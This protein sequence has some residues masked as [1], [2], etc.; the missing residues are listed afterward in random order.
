[1]D[2]RLLL[3][4]L[5]LGLAGS[6][7][8][9]PIVLDY[10]TEIIG[11][12][13][14]CR[15]DS[16]SWGAVHI[17]NGD[18]MVS[19][20]EHRWFREPS[21]EYNDGWWGRSV[22]FC[23]DKA[24]AI[25]EVRIWN[26]AY[27]YRPNGGAIRNARLFSWDGSDWVEVWSGGLTQTPAGGLDDTFE[28]TDTINLAGVVTERVKFEAVD[29]Y[30]SE[31][32]VL[33]EI[34]FY[35]S[36]ATPRIQ[37]ETTSSDGLES[38]SPAGLTVTLGNAEA[39]QTCTVD[40]AAAGGSAVRGIDY[41]LEPGT[42]TFGPGETT[43]TIYI[44]I[45]DDGADEEDETIV[46]ALS[47][48]TTTG[49]AVVL[50]DPN[51]HTYTILD[52][53]SSVGFDETGSSRTED[54]GTIQIQV[55]L[56]SASAKTIM[57]DY[58]VTGGTATG[59][60][61]DYTLAP[62]TLTFNPGET[63]KSISVDVVDD[64]LAEAPETVVITLSNQ[65]HLKLGTR[66][67]TIEITD[68]FYPMT[69]LLW[70][71]D[72]V[73]ATANSSH[74][75][76]WEPRNTINRDGMVSADEHGSWGAPGDGTPD[77]SWMG[78]SPAGV[79]IEWEFARP[80]RIVDMWLWNGSY[81]GR[82]NGGSIKGCTIEY[83]YKSQWHTLTS[84]ELN[85]W[86]GGASYQKTD[87]IEFGR[88]TAE[89]VRLTVHSTYESDVSV[90][91]EVRF[92]ISE[93]PGVAFGT[94]YSGALESEGPAVLSV[95]LMYIHEEGQTYTVDY[96]VTGGT[97]GG[98]G[99]D[100]TLAGYCDCDFD[101]NNEVDFSDIGV[102][103]ANWLEQTPGG[104][105]DIAG[106]E[107]VNFDDFVVCAAEWQRPCTGGTLVF[108]PG[109]RSKTITID[110]VDD[111][112]DEE[113]ETIVV[114]LSNPTS[115]GDRIVPGVPD[116]HIYTILDPRPG[117]GFDSARS[118]TREDFGTIDISV[119]ISAASDEVVT[120]D[121]YV[122]GG[123][124]TG[125]GV[126]YTLDLRT[127]TF[128]PGELS[129]TITIVLAEDDEIEDEETIVVALSNASTKFGAITEHTA[130]VHDPW[131]VG[132]YEVFK[133][134]LACPRAVATMKEGWIAF[135]GGG[136]CDGAKHDGRATSNIA[137]TGINAYIDNVPGGGSVNLKTWAG[138]PICNTAFMQI[139][140]D[141]F[142]PPA[143]S[144]KIV[145]SGSGLVAGEYWVYAFHNWPEWSIIPEVT[146][147][148]AGVTQFE[149]T[150]NVAI[151]K[152]QFDGELVPSVVKFHTDG[153]GPV[154]I[155]Y[156]AA[157]GA[158]AVV[159][160]FALYTPTPPEHATD[161]RPK[162]GATDVSPDV[163]LS[164]TAGTGADSH[165]VYLGAD[166]TAVDSATSASDE[167]KGNQTDTTYVPDGL[168]DFGQKYYWRIDEVGDAG[169]VKGKVWNFTVADGKASN[170]SPTD[171]S[172]NIATE[173]TLSWT[174]GVLAQAHDVYL[175]IAPETLALVS[176]GQT[177]TTYDPGFLP[178]VTIYY[179]RVDETGPAGTVEGDVWNFSTQGLIRLRVDLAL[180]AN[181]ATTE[182]WPG[183]LK[184]GWTP[185]VAP[186]WYDMYMHDAVWEKGEGGEGPPPET[187]G[188]D[189]TGVHVA[190]GCGG[191]GNGGF[192]VHGMCRCGLAGG[193][194]ATGNPAGEPIANGFYQNIDWGGEIGGDILMR[195]NGLPPGEYELI[196]YHNHWEP[197][198]QATRNC[199][200][201]QS[202]MPPIGTVRA[203]PLPV[204]RLPE[205]GKW[206]FTPGTGEGVESLQDDFNIDVTS[207][208]SDA[209]VATSH[210]RFRTN[211]SDVL[212][213]YGGLSND[214]PDPARSG[215]EGHKAILNA[216][217]IRSP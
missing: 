17:V 184:Q 205:Y 59:G 43:R 40:Y 95:D 76:T 25:D 6:A 92:Y 32:A 77:H 85:K 87:V 117:V 171:H 68:P 216:F 52:P 14:A 30:D 156:H 217:E 4:A 5:V 176:S 41:T 123:T 82:D 174:A 53:R 132:A 1:M 103:A 125:G 65:T 140:T 141:V 44:D 47:N 27:L 73:R 107:S 81:T 111:G 193:C 74:G 91:A 83:Y 115:T 130:V 122:G 189:G 94:A 33:S 209:D 114:S 204:E 119:S 11:F 157:D 23:F 185:Y 201:E 208:T 127:L 172:G 57:V 78:D 196:S 175:G 182:P 200:N 13:G 203:M 29:T 2:K 188:L 120:V 133:V 147:S 104:I 26:G 75:G 186:R 143:G 183:T 42:L 51:E 24:Y 38:V 54:W 159:N 55:S 18:G 206:N 66:E 191:V 134:D 173:A 101:D 35:G 198:T 15:G 37:F 72:I 139:I 90:L 79:W 31:D 169:T 148:G 160:A 144:I 163:I 84:T 62:G 170:P 89:K 110:I 152:V 48:P 106:D 61:A 153:S 105:A 128:D 178:A 93:P 168:A 211:G 164:W 45:V 129:K 161:P 199:M 22:E 135:E 118:V 10:G 124:A 100:Y 150:T 64:G 113:D 210:V 16:R 3:V 7:C 109:E 177:S 88:V 137:D 149:P 20:T 187:T 49:E 215:R 97:A 212:V 214:Y 36:V 21:A 70:G 80:Y 197:R 142:G 86:G 155:T 99:V 151:Q 213:I 158:K 116:E 12:G 180:P 121:Y 154:T 46:V 194:P 69:E 166:E 102:L 179:W 112:L 202:N 96:A 8:A 67:H 34:Q 71:T 39:G 50:V 58:E 108:D 60:G 28:K 19:E 162:K 98:G 192:H 126:D 190:L 63:T 56:S 181:A 146:A 195:I 138:E 136:W 145:L 167:Y 131:M 207:V 165:D 9:E